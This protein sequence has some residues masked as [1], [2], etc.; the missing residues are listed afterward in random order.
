MTLPGL[1]AQTASSFTLSS[2][3]FTDGGTLPAE[4]TCDGKRAS[5]PLTWSNAPA[6]TRFFAVTMHHIPAPG[7]K[8]VYLVVYNIPATVTSLPENARDIG[9]FGINTVNGQQEYTPPCSKGPGPKLYTMTVY[10]LSSEAKFAIPANNVTMDDLLLAIQ[11]KTLSTAAMSVTYSRPESA[12]NNSAGNPPD[13][14]NPPKDAGHGGA[15][16]PRELETA[17]ANLNL[18]GDQKQKVDAA[19]QDFQDK[20]RQL[21]ESLLQNLKA[22]LNADQYAEVENAFQ[23][24]PAQPSDRPPRDDN[25]PPGDHPNP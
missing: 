4:F 9:V 17:L 1:H 19:V 6:A 2:P 8:H 3:A 24:P 7:E 16:I 14:G 5:P 15:R 11:D 12:M 22:V 23:K 25:Q 13:A 21:R 10:A 18:S 20:Q